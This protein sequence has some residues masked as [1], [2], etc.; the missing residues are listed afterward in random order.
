MSVDNT[1]QQQRQ[2]QR[3]SEQL[4][5]QIEVTLVVTAA[6]MAEIPRRRCVYLLASSPASPSCSYLETL[7]ENAV[8]RHVRRRIAPVRSI[9]AMGER[10]A[11]VLAHRTGRVFALSPDPDGGARRENHLRDE[12]VGEGGGGG[13]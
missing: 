12:C 1:Q 9:E 4:N 3:G 6:T 10:A 13:A 2:R 7:K 11:L 5:A 8:P